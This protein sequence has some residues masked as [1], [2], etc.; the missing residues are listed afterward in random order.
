MWHMIHQKNRARRESI[1]EGIFQFFDIRDPWDRTRRPGPICRIHYA[2]TVSLTLC[3]ILY[4][5][6]K[7]LKT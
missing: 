7:K 5:I 1:R 4:E 6:I 3:C 2:Y